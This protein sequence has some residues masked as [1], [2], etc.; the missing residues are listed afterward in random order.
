VN[1]ANGQTDKTLVP[2]IRM[3]IAMPYF[4][5]FN[6]RKSQIAV[7]GNSLFGLLLKKECRVGGKKKAVLSLTQITRNKTIQTRQE[8][9]FFC[10]IKV[11]YC[12]V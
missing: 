9:L 12:F 10:R 2:Y 8:V 1:F 11:I 3:I 5:Q 4:R 6:A 7:S